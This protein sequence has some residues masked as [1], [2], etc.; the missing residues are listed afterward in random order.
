[1]EPTIAYLTGGEYS[2][3]AERV[4]LEKRKKTCERTYEAGK[5]DSSS[6][7]RVLYGKV[8]HRGGG[9]NTPDFQGSISGRESNKEWKRM[10]KVG[11]GSRKVRR[12]CWVCLLENLDERCSAKMRG[13]SSA[14]R[15][16]GSRG[17][18]GK[19]RKYSPAK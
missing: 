18:G 6:R 12:S 14:T 7:F 19:H 4:M 1:V 10:R 2:S 16:S 13:S 8:G 5:K 15:G 17:D 9:S 3:F 11:G